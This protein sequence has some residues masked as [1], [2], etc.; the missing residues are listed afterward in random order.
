MAGLELCGLDVYAKWHD[1]FAGEEVGY[2]IEQVLWHGIDI[3]AAIEK[4]TNA[5]EAL[6][7]Q[8]EG[9]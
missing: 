7:E 2:S 8:V 9:A 3:T 6:T 1:G 4:T 5:M